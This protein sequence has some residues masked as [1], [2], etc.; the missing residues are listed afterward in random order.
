MAFISKYNGNCQTGT[1]V[2]INSHKG[3]KVII[4]CTV[5]QSYLSLS[6]HENV[7][8]SL[9]FARWMMRISSLISLLFSCRKTILACTIKSVKNRQNI[10]I[11]CI[12]SFNLKSFYSATSA[13]PCMKRSWLLDKEAYSSISWTCHFTLLKYLWLITIKQW[14][15]FCVFCFPLI[16]FTLGVCVF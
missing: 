5:H 7:S 14:R 9:M 15:L 3:I 16:S 11:N 6:L 12:R 4:Y 10:C 1:V 2:P 13:L 8:V